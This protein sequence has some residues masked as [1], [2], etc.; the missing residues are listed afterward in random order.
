M[1]KDAEV[2][3]GDRW[4]GEQHPVYVIAEIGINHHG[5]TLTLPVDSKKL[6]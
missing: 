5:V 3:I 6:P 1:D 4:V 2:K